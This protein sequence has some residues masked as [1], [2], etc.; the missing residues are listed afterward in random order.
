LAVDV[1]PVDASVVSPDDEES[2]AGTVIDRF[3]VA[4][5]PIRVRDGHDGIQR[6][7]VGT[8]EPSEEV[9]GAGGALFPD[10]EKPPLGV[11]VGDGRGALFGITLGEN[12]GTADGAA[13]TLPELPVDLRCQPDVAPDEDQQVAVVP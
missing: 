3:R 2:A 9:G 11:I 10:D 7:P 5:I 13:V 1:V 8:D 4:L 12:K 6:G